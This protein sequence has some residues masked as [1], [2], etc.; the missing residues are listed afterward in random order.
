[1]END[2]TAVDRRVFLRWAGLG[3]VLA[4]GGWKVAAAATQAAAGHG[5][6]MAGSSGIVRFQATG[7]L[8][9]A[10]LPAYATQVVAGNVDVARKSGVVSSMIL[11]GA[12][13]GGVA[14]PGLSRSVRVTGVDESGQ[15]LRITGVVDD[16]SQLQAGESATVQLR[17][18]R[19]NGVVFANVHGHEVE[20]K[21]VP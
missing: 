3:G 18:N 14:L 5:S 2:T 9:K 19:A 8:P 15:E 20:L 4:A 12:G 17:V 11:A 10:P 7:E 21:L 6:A 16:R 13:G 1:M